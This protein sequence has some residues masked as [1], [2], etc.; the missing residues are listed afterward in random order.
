MHNDDVGG[1][2]IDACIVLSKQKRRLTTCARAWQEENTVRRLLKSADRTTFA[3]LFT[4]IC[5]IGGLEW[6]H[7]LTARETERNEAQ[8]TTLAMTKENVLLAH[9]WFEEWVAGDASI[10]LDTDVFQHLDAGIAALTTLLEPDV[11]AG[12]ASL[13]PGS[14][15]DDFDKLR[16]EFRRLRASAQARARDRAGA[17][18]VGGT[19][20][21]EFDAI[22]R[23]ILG[24]QNALNSTIGESVRQSKRSA[25]WRR[26]GVLAG[27]GFLFF[28]LAY[29]VYQRRNML[30]SRNSELE[31]RVRARTADLQRAME[32]AEASSRAKSQFLAT[33][34]HE[35][36]T[37]LNAIIG[38]TGLLL[39]TN[40]NPQQREFAETTRTSSEALLALIS[41][42]LDYSRIESGK[43]QLEEGVLEVRACIEEALELVTD[44]AVKKQLEIGCV[45]ER[46]TTPVVIGDITR[47]RQV[48]VNLLSNA[49]KFTPAGEVRVRVSSRDIDAD[50]VELHFEISDTGI[51]IPAERMDRLFQSFSQVDA[52]TTREYGGTGLGLAI[53]KQLCALMGGKI[54]VESTV[55]KGS[56]FHFTIV[57]HRGQASADARDALRVQVLQGK[58]M[59]VVDDNAT[60]RRIVELQ[61]EPW[62]MVLHMAASGAEALAAIEGQKVFDIVLL[63]AQ[64]PNID[65]LAVAT[66]I[67]KKYDPRTLPIILY[68][69]SI[70]YDEATIRADLGLVAILMK[71]V[72]QSRLVDTLV[73]ALNKTEEKNE[74]PKT[75]PAE[76][77]LLARTHPLRILLAEDNVINQRVALAML[78]RLG[79]RADVVANGVEAVRALELGAYDV[80]LMD[81]QM[82]EMD[83]ITASRIIREK[84]S[85]DKQPYIIAMTANVSTDDRDA[86]VAAG[87]NDFV[88]KPMRVEGVL[89]ALSR[90]GQE[91]PAQ[92]RSF[93]PSSEP[94]LDAEKIAALRELGALEEIV[95]EFL[96]EAPVRIEAIRHAIAEQR[97][98]TVKLEAHALKGASGVVGATSLAKTAAKLENAS[99]LQNLADVSSLVEQLERNVEQTRHALSN[100]IEK[101]NEKN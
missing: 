15:R 61:T 50:R 24:R 95:H 42:I 22:F 87:M 30:V 81:I 83:G 75:E 16:E 71:P 64:M 70:M 88:G 3:V 20:D 97:F 17:G 74:S 29:L 94:A 82:P 60:N 59:L 63:D 2:W 99:K 85:K 84:I 10:V 35:I 101:R 52:S 73:S 1:V 86:C 37:P 38:M 100:E 19:E 25:D 49:V 12:T 96:S 80:V 67:R 90:V 11:R 36:R 98:D 23:S 93:M 27:L 18:Q 39:D 62:G 76:S 89:T 56:T 4:G 44:A 46:G 41:D 9:L 33:M 26:Q 65:G 21:Q 31:A 77:L 47:L 48:L 54:W 92:S 57:A 69:S 7:R 72:R 79:Y 51:G 6:S 43:L 55:G 91:K 28:G 34:S 53:C 13:P 78:S 66:T 14:G 5:C 8:L 40:L 58:R 68:S 45:F 32:L